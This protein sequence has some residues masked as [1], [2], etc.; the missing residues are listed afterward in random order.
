ML[1]A[2]ISVHL[3]IWFRRPPGINE[4]GNDFKDERLDAFSELIGAYHIVCL[5][6]LFGA[7]S[8]RQQKL[9]AKAH[10]KGFKYMIKSPRVSEIVCCTGVLTCAVSS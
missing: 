1:C 3:R 8:A 7:F 2:S 9:I 4:H 10:E 5:Q 6:E